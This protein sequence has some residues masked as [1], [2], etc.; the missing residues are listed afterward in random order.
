M[1]E[2][3][4]LGTEWPQENLWAVSSMIRDSLCTPNLPIC[5]LA[6]ISQVGLGVGVTSFWSSGCWAFWVPL[7][8][9]P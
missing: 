1:A 7:V 9:F 6:Q 4:V 8:C 5:P 3:L 2:I